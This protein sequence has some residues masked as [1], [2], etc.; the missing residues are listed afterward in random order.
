MNSFDGYVIVSGNGKPTRTVYGTEIDAWIGELGNDARKIY[1]AQIA[2][3]RAVFVRVREVE[4]VG[5][6]PV[7]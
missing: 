7:V 3:Y 1:Q 5:E 4:L 2:G 6:P